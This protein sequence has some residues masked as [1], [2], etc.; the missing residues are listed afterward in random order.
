MNNIV[1][2]LAYTVGWFICVWLASIE[3]GNLAALIAFSITGVQLFFIFRANRY[4]FY[5]DLFLL[6]FALFFAFLLETI[7]INFHIIAYKNNFSWHP[8]IWLL[9]LYSL[10]LI[11]LNHSFNSLNRYS[12]IAP[13][14]GG[15]GAPLSYRAG[16]LLQADQ[17]AFH[18]VGL[19]LSIGIL[20][21]IYLF[22]MVRLNLIL[23]K[24]VDQVALR[25]KKSYLLTIIYDKKGIKKKHG[26][27]SSGKIVKGADFLSAFYAKK[28][29]TFLAILLQIGSQFRKKSKT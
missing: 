3:W 28:R 1:N 24:A 5:Q 12:F 27:D 10:F 11:T 19:F 14:V 18:G 7:F 29:R 6:I 13:I 22:A 17:L 26:V 15:L 8:P 4:L 25:E 21:G 23:K 2:A 9:G 16:H 20:W